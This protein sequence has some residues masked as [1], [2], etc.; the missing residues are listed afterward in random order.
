[1]VIEHDSQGKPSYLQGKL[2][3]TV[4]IGENFYVVS[5]ISKFVKN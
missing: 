2:V 3:G 5:A 1:M 4:L